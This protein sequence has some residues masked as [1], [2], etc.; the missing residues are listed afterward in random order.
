MRFFR[1]TLGQIGSIEMSQ[2]NKEIAAR[3]FEAFW[4]S[5]WQPEIADDLAA[6]D[7]V[8]HHSVYEPMRG[9]TAVIEFM[10]E[11]RR[12]FPDLK[13]WTVGDLIAEG[14]YVVCRWKGGG[15]HTGPAFC[16]FRTGSLPAASGRSMR[17]SGTAVLRV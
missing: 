1:D 11:F 7:M 2:A 5:S 12:A 13:F 14:D 3:W 6:P 17:F 10:T 15:S 8:L 4:G 16:G 9:R